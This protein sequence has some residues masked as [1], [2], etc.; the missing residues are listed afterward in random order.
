MRV[1][2]RHFVE[3][4]GVSEVQRRVAKH[5]NW[6]FR[7]QATSDFGIDAEI[8]VVRGGQATGRLLA[9]QIKSGPSYFGE[10]TNDG[11]VYRGDT[12]HLDYWLNHS[13]PVIIVLWNPQT[14]DCLWQH[15][16]EELIE[17]TTKGW[18]IAVPKAQ[19]I[20]RSS[21]DALDRV[22]GIPRSIDLA[23]HYFAEPSSFLLRDLIR[24]FL[25]VGILPAPEQLHWVYENL[26]PGILAPEEL[27]FLWGSW[28]L[29]EDESEEWAE[30]NSAFSFSHYVPVLLKHSRHGRP[31]LEEKTDISVVQSNMRFLRGTLIE[32]DSDGSF[33]NARPASVGGVLPYEKVAQIVVGSSKRS[34]LAIYAYILASESSAIEL[35]VG[36]SRSLTA[37]I[38]RVETN[39]E[40]DQETA[41]GWLRN[42]TK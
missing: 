21:M 17:R 12:E 30:N 34:C 15:V 4:S 26:D 10:E 6:L 42:R 11:Y 5:L 24:Q 33:K 39:Q 29:K 20:G 28:R 35:L 31:L 16:T 41:L 37:S 3:R 19:V 7:E 38:R 14:D 36:G 18:K 25:V 32:V 2:E 13:L 8:E 1:D 27:A 23:E 40:R 9:A 22:A